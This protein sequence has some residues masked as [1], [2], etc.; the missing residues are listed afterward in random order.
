[1]R[2][3]IFLAVFFP[4]DIFGQ[5]SEIVVVDSVLTKQT[6]YSNCLSWF[7]VSFKS[8]N[9]VIQMKDLETGK[10][11]GK[12]ILNSKVT[13]MGINQTGNTYVT[14]TISLRNGK[15]KYEFNDIRWEYAN[16]G[17]VWSW[18]VAPNMANK[19]WER[20]KADVEREINNIIPGLKKSMIVKSDF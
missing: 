9:S 20:W 19:P 7:A 17:P 4:L 14:I 15:Y 5:F 6:L 16:S 3:I 10:I 11:I 2:V 12:G 8:A 13:A 1:M 18:D